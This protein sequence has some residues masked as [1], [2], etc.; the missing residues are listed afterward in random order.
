MLLNSLNN[1]QH[2]KCGYQFDTRVAV[3]SQPLFFIGIKKCL[4]VIIRDTQSSLGK[5]INLLVIDYF[6]KV[7]FF[8]R[9]H[10]GVNW[11]LMP[12]SG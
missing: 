6:M 12:T 10:F 11:S 2:W 3:K 8:V 4:K 5:F 1:G 9:H 7:V